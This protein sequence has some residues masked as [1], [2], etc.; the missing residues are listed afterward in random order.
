MIYDNIGAIGG[1]RMTSSN[2]VYANYDQFAPH[3]SMACNTKQRVW[4]PNL[5]LLGPVKTELW[6][7]EVGELSVM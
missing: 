3:F 6:V 2:Q 4:V 7:K 5:K 1:L